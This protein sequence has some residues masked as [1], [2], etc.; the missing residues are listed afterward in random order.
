[1]LVVRCTYSPPYYGI[2]DVSLICGHWFDDTLSEYT[3][4][5][6]HVPVVDGVAWWHWV[7]HEPTLIQ[8]ALHQVFDDAFPPGKEPYAS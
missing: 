3:P 1:M 5:A 6:V 2:G 8:H 7:Q 4:H